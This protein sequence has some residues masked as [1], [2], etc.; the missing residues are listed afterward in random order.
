MCYVYETIVAVHC[1]EIAKDA[2]MFLWSYLQNDQAFHFTEQLYCPKKWWDSKIF[3]QEMIQNSHFL[4]LLYL[5]FLLLEVIHDFH[6]LSLHQTTFLYVE[7]FLCLQTNVGS[8][9]VTSQDWQRYWPGLNYLS[10]DFLN[11]LI[12][13]LLNEG[14]HVF[15]LPQE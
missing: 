6:S 7:F 12:G 5:L 1:V 10:V 8:Y 9:W 2:V 3:I 14:H 4:M 11:F 13:F 15:D